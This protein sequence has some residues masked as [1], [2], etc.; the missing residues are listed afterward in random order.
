MVQVHWGILVESILMLTLEWGEGIY[1]LL[2][3]VNVE[4]A[5]ASDMFTV[6]VFCIML[7]C[8]TN[9]RIYTYVA[10]APIISA[11]A[12]VRTVQRSMHVRAH[13]LTYVRTYVHVPRVYIA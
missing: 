2:K 10:R 7:F 8:V 5:I 12:Y 13:T 3:I 4:V 11:H 6:C 9:V 1:I